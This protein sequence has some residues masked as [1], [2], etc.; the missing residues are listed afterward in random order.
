MKW[1]QTY[2]AQLKYAQAGSRRSARTCT[3]PTSE[4]AGVR[5]MKAMVDSAPHRA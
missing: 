3:A 4:E 2:D 5:W 1:F